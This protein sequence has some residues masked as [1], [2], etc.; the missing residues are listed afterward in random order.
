[1]GELCGKYG[2]RFAPATPLLRMTEKGEQF[3]QK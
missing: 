2:D 1:M 3:H